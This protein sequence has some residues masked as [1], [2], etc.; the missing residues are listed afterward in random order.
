VLTTH[1]A[2]PDAAVTAQVHT[3]LAARALTPS[4]HY[5]DSGYPSAALL[6]TSKLEHGIDLVTPLLGNNSAQAKAGN[7]FERDAFTLD[8]DHQQAT[9]PRGKTSA[10]WNP[11][12]PPR[13]TPAIVVSFAK[14]D[15]HPCPDRPLCTSA[16]AGMRQITVPPREVYHLQQQARATE[17]TP[18]WQARYATRAGVEGTINQAVNLGIRRTRYRGIDKTRLHHILTACVINLTRLDAYWNGHPLDRTRTSHL[19]RLELSL[20]A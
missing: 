11:V 3:M 10:T 8:F 2:V 17:K 13:R 15:C 7:G 9:C 5:L 6:L 20:T 16:K 19:T 12:H 4:E 14:T 1:A 18:Q